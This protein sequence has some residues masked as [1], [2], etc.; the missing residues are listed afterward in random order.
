[1]VLHVRLGG[2]LTNTYCKKQLI[3]KYY[4]GPWTW[5][6][7]LEMDGHVA[8]MREM[9]NAYKIL[10]RKSEGKKPLG[11]PN[12]DWRIILEIILFLFFFFPWLH[13]AA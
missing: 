13:S 9:R 5:T 12:V 8:R 2:G 7:S 10:I 6:D 1:V 3:T 4:T 11:R